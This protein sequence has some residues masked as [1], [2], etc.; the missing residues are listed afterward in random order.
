MSCDSQSAICLSKNQVHQ[1]RTK[2]IDVWFHF[3]REIVNEEDTHLLKIR[4]ADNSADMF[5]KVIARE[6]FWYCLDL[7][8]V[9]GK[10]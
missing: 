7:I 1:A 8:N 9:G 6:K 3:V 10:K 2:H 4:I 5:T